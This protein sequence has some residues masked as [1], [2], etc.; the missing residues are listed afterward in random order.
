MK[1]VFVILID[2]GH[3]IRLATRVRHL[4]E[5]GTAS[6][7]KC[8]YFYH[9]AG[10]YFCYA[11]VLNRYH[12]LGIHFF[13]DSISSLSFHPKM[14]L[15]VLYY[16]DFFENFAENTKKNEQTN[17]HFRWVRRHTLLYTHTHTPE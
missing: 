8:D 2:L 3:G 15:C 4:A 6:Q 1:H 13:S 10:K 11:L 5:N 14:R 17:K 7:A 12:V 9:C 16:F